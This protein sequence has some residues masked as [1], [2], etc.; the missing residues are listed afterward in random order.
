MDA[1]G[2]AS[3]DEVVACLREERG[4]RAETKNGPRFSWLKTVVTDYFSQKRD[5]QAG[6]APV[7]VTE[8]APLLSP[9]PEG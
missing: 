7:P 6:G 9:T 5:R 4:L 8:L 3:E 1:A 2:G